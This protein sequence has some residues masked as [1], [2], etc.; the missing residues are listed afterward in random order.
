MSLLSLHNV[1]KRFGGLQAVADTSK[2][3][4]GKIAAIRTLAEHTT[5]HVRTLAAS[6][7]GRHV[8]FVEEYDPSLPPVFANRDQL[9]QVF[10]KAPQY[11]CLDVSL[12][13]A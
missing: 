12:E 11:P 2:W 1:G 8:R 3:T 10:L 4:T 13:R 6:G 7:F 5:E 9:I